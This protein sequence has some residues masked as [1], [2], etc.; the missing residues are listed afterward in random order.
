[1]RHDDPFVTPVLAG[2]IRE[3]GRRMEKA[4][5]VGTLE[6]WAALE[7]WHK[8][9]F[10]RTWRVHIHRQRRYTRRQDGRLRYQPTAR[11]HQETNDGP[12]SRA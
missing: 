3:L 11:Y 6:A 12:A 10:D 9:T 5:A 4:R 8:R 2:H 7:A 1:M